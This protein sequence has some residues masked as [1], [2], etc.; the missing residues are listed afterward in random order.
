MCY[1]LGLNSQHNTY[2]N[3]LYQRTSNHIGHAYRFMKGIWYVFIYKQNINLNFVLGSLSNTLDALM[4][5]LCIKFYGVL[6]INYLTRVYIYVAYTKE[7]SNT[8]T[9]APSL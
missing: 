2:L 4:N 8:Q 6:Y 9:L 5:N 3:K 1:H 7:H